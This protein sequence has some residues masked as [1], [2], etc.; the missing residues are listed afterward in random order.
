MHEKFTIFRTWYRCRSSTRKMKQLSVKSSR[1]MSGHFPHRIH[2]Q[3]I[4]AIGTNKLWTRFS[5]GSPLPIWLSHLSE[6][7]QK[8]RKNPAAIVW[9][10]SSN[11]QRSAKIDKCIR[12]NLVSFIQSCRCT[13]TDWKQNCRRR[14]V[15]TSEPN[16]CKNVNCKMA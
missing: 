12:W 3:P 4:E 11:R 15:R 13:R 1:G 10:R 8:K 2:K 5:V 7:K 9:T 16:K 14:T 6:W